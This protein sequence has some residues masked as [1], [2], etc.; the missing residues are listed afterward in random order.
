MFSKWALQYYCCVQVY[1]PKRILGKPSFG[2]Y[3]V[4]E[5]SKLTYKLDNTNHAYTI[6]FVKANMIE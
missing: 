4:R 5:I 1:S 3:K 2:R 6:L